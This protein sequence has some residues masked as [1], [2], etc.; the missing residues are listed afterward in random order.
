[1]LSLRPYQRESLDALYAHWQAGG[2]NG[3]IVLPTGAGKALVIAALVR[4]TLTQWPDLRIAMVTSTKE[5]I[6]QNAQ[7]LLR[8]WPGAPIGIYSAGLGRRDI[9]SRILFCGI[10]SVHSKAR[11]VG[12][13]DLVIVDECFVAGTPVATPFGP[14][15]IEAIKPGD[16]VENAVG[17]G[18]VEATR[19]SHSNE[20]YEVELSNG[21]RLRCT[22]N[23]PFFTDRGW[24]KSSELE[25][26]RRLYS[27]KELRKLQLDIQALDQEERPWCRGL[28]HEASTVGE[29][30]V[31]FNLLLE[32]E[33]E[34]DGVDGVP[35]ENGTN[36]ER[37][38]PQTQN[39]RRQWNG[40]YGHPIGVVER[41]R[42][43]MDGK[44]FNHDWNAEGRRLSLTL[45]SKSCERGGSNRN[46]NDPAEIPHD[47]GAILGESKGIEGICRVV[48]V[49]RIEGAPKRTVYNLQVSGHPS[50]FAHGVLTHNCHLIPRSAD[51]GYG[52][53]L[54]GLRDATPDMR[55][56]GLTATPFRLDTGRLDKGESAM[57]ERVVYDAHVGDLI[58]DGYL[59][60]LISRATHTALDTTGVPK[61]GGDFVPGAL[62]AAVDIEETT[63]AAVAE[64]ALHGRERRAW[65]A[66]CAGVE[67]AQHVAEAIRAAGFSCAVVTGETPAG[68]RDRIIADYRAGRIRCLSSVGVLTTGFNVPQVD[69]IALLRPTQSAG[70]YIQMVGRAL[71]NA[72]GKENALILDFGRLLKTH[73]P[74]DAIE[75]K[76]RSK[77]G[78][79][80]PVKE[81]LACESYV[82]AGTMTCEVCG[83]VFPPRE[84]ERHE[85]KAE[86]SL[87]I[88]STEAPPWIPVRDWTFRRHR[89]PGSPDSLC[90][91]F[92][93]GIATHR[94][95]IC[96]EQEGFARTKAERWWADRGGGW[97]PSSVTD[98][99][100]RAA[101]LD[102]PAE[103]RVRKNGKFTEIV[104]YRAAS[105][106][107]AAE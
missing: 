75:I 96:L 46:F 78:G 5:L 21:R 89:K 48:S 39:A 63:R 12:P 17:V 58:R 95:W 100:E 28:D 29:T 42:P 9:R 103:I 2:G 6:A 26:G 69:L 44:S 30:E 76:D 101:E 20:I 81:C 73:G 93:C 77:A 16:L 27:I 33:R 54:A 10:Q 15:A 70:L 41:T 3:L 94:T 102:M 74:I 25:K 40:S 80:A 88:L 7:E 36:A 67:H 31:L 19:T 57:F 4:E 56:V 34:C 53:F 47:T 71:R 43:P 45:Q 97:A 107:M 85:A 22:G 86:S 50:F 64:M 11:Q 62:A 98:G 60:K 37:D 59:C 104:G 87:N 68:E 82:P 14:V 72:P 66:F 106:P 105:A 90:V 38:R 55:V 83:H 79:P 91:E 32:A 52:R 18:V 1:M 61:R 49:R 51:T 99:L 23:H 65:L 35:S 92:H 8:Y 13:F 84:I 24:T